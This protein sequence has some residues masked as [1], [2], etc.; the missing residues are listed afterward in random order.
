MDKEK[1]FQKEKELTKDFYKNENYNMKLGGQGGFTVE[2][3][4]K[5]WK[6]LC[7][8]AGKKSV[9]LGYGYGGK[10]QK[11]AK[12]CGRK[13]GLA[14]KGKPKTEEHKQKK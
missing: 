5:G 6:A 11:D 1:A 14:N 4:K 13:G 3:A 9:Q 10:N 12:E 7:K 2:N 8:K